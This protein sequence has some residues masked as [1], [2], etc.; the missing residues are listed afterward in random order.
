VVD[1]LGPIERVS[2][3]LIAIIEDRGTNGRQAS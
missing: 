2:A 3:E 1:A